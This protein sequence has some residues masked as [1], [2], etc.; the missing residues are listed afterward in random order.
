MTSRG[1]YWGASIE[2][3][4]REEKEAAGGEILIREPSVLEVVENRI[5]FY[6]RVDKTTI[7]K[8]NRELRSLNNEYISQAQRREDDHLTPIYLHISSYGGSIFSGLAGLD[9]IRRSV[10]PVYTIV[11]GCCA[12][13]ATFLSVVGKR[14]FINSHSFMMIHQLS[15]VMWGKYAEFED[16]MKNLDRL[17]VMIKAIYNEFT[18][19]PSDKLDEILQHDLWFDAQA[20]LEYGL[21]DEII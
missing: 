15:S 18:E 13:A 8:L 14:R 5:Y 6:A 3:K 1:R 19:V 10:V 9:Q 11:D 7:L 4:E 2:E 20:C 17:M 21:V 16:E 12:S